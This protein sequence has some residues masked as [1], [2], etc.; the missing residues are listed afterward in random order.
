MDQSLVT[1]TFIQTVVVCS[2]DGVSVPRWR[3]WRHEGLLKVSVIQF[4]LT[5]ARFFSVLV[6]FLAL[7]NRG[8]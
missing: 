5:S 6:N 1:F 7:R 4:M 3:T 2:F 8:S